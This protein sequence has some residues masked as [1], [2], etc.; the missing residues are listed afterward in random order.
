MAKNKLARS[1]LYLLANIKNIIP[2]LPFVMLKQNT[3][4]V[5]MPTPF[6]AIEPVLIQNYMLA[7]FAPR[8]NVQEGQRDLE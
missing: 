5:P 1:S 3:M 8:R 7:L 4:Q 6:M 2:V